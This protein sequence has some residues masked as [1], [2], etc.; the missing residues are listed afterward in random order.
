MFSIVLIANRGENAL[1]II[2]TC[3]ELGLQTVAVYSEA[4]VHSLH[5]EQADEKVCIGPAPS[6]KVI[7]TESGLSRRPKQ[8]VRRPFIP[9]TVIWRKRLLCPVV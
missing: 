1:R 6:I 3:R 4:D 2:R 7:W 8:R 9:V 5:L